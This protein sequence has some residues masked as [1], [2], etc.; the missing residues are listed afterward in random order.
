MNFN[1][2]HSKNQIRESLQQEFFSIC[3][4][5]IVRWNSEDFLGI[6]TKHKEKHENINFEMRIN[7]NQTGGGAF[8]PRDFL[9]SK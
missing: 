5:N 9:C 2:T 6:F 4:R 3:V 1:L 7:P 8:L